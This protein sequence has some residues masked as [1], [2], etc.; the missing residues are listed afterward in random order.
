MLASSCNIQPFYLSCLAC[1]ATFSLSIYHVWPVLQHSAALFI[2][3]ALSCNIQPLYLSC[4]TCLDKFKPF[5]HFPNKNMT[6]FYTF[7]YLFNP[8]IF[9]IVNPIINTSNIHISNQ[10]YSNPCPL[11]IIFVKASPAYLNGNK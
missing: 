9:K 10:M 5:I 1:L 7:L 11:I 3:F 8:T 6:F 4:W 2:M